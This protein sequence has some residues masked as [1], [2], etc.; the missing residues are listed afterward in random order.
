MQCFKEGRGFLVKKIW[1]FQK[2]IYNI[3]SWCCGSVIFRQ[4]LKCHEFLLFTYLGHL[5]F[6][7]LNP[8][9]LCQ[10]ISD[11]L[12]QKILSVDPVKKENKVTACYNMVERV[13]WP[14]TV[15]IIIAQKNPYF[16]EYWKINS[17]YSYRE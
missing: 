1:Y 17:N 7:L 14:L 10:Y 2:T 6:N 5:C 3:K 8:V 16:S 12:Q 15:M 9:H 13:S 4:A 11:P